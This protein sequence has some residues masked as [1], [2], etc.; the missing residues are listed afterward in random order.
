MSSL[1]RRDEEPWTL[2]AGLASMSDSLARVVTTALVGKQAAQELVFK[3]RNYV[4]VAFTKNFHE[5]TLVYRMAIQVI[6][7]IPMDC[8]GDVRNWQL[9]LPLAKRD[10]AHD[11]YE[12]PK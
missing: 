9:N 5:G 8:N 4:W 1:F 11:S 6:E 10:F 3:R 7:L 12:S 2:G